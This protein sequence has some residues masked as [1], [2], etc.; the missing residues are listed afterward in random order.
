MTVNE[1]N[2]CVNQYADGVFRFILKNIKDEDKAKDIVQ[3]AFEKL[4][5]KLSDIDAAT[6]K[7]YLF[8]IAYNGM[9]DAFRREKFVGDIE[10]AKDNNFITF[11]NYND[12]KEILNEALSKLND[13]QRAVVLLRDYEGY[14]YKEIGKITGLSESQVK[15]YIYRAR[16]ILKEYIG[17]LYR[18]I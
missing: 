17:N 7:S 1:Y 9:V 2:N 10:S 16:V 8:T 13:I 6:V 3:D 4:W 5:I 11:N 14:N 15:V 12:V 18:V